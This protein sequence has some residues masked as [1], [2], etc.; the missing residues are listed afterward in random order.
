[1][2]LLLTVIALTALA[3][4]RDAMAPTSATPAAGGRAAEC[5]SPATDDFGTPTGG[6]VV[7]RS[8]VD[9]T[10]TWDAIP[11]AVW[12]SG[13]IEFFSDGGWHGWGLGATNTFRTEETTFSWSNHPSLEAEAYDFRVRVR[14]RVGDT[15]SD[16]SPWAYA[17]RQGE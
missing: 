11:E 4:C 17:C 5:T 14:A 12:Y 3:S 8:G 15:F 6:V 1:M 7:E 10:A 13:E 16:F 9:L 2:K